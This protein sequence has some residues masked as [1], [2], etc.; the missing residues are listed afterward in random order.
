[1]CGI[2]GYF[3]SM[4]DQPVNP[5]WVW[6]MVGIQYHRGP[7][8]QDVYTAPGLALGHNR[9]SIIDL[10]PRSNQPM[11]DT[12]SG[13]IIVFNGEIYNY[14][15]LREELG[16]KGYE[17]HTES[18][19]EVLLKA[20]DEWGQDCVNHFNG[21]W[22][23]ALYDPQAK[24][25]FLSRDR[26]G[27][28]PLVYGFRENGDFVFASEAKAIYSTFPEFR[29]PN[30]PFIAS[31]I[32][33]GS[34]A[35]YQE[36]F[37]HGLY[38]LLP[39]NSLVL[40]ANFGIN[41]LGPEKNDV[42]QERYYR[43]WYPSDDF[44]Q[45]EKFTDKQIQEKFETLLQDA[46]RLRFRSDVP[47]GACLSGGLDS[48]TIVGLAKKMNL[49]QNA[50]ESS[51][52]TFSCVYP[53]SPSDDES[54]YIQKAV[55]AFGTKSY[56]TTPHYDH[57]LQAAYD[58]VWEQDGPTGG[59][60]VLSQ[61]SVMKEASGRVTVL[62]DGQ[63]ADE[64]LGG[65]H[66]LF[67]TAVN[68]LMRQYIRT[69]KPM[70]WFR[71]LWNTQQIEQRTG[72]KFEGARKLYKRVKK[73]PVKF[74]AYTASFSVLDY[75]SPIHNDDLNTLLLELTLMNLPSLL[76]YEDRNSMRFSLE[77]R[78]PFLDYRIV[79]FAFSLP[80]L[81]KIRGKITK[82]MVFNTAKKILP[83][84]ILNRKDK[85]GFNTPAYPWFWQNETIEKLENLLHSNKTTQ[86]QQVFHL[87]PEFYQNLLNSAFERLKTKDKSNPDDLVF[88]W[89]FMTSG[90][91]FEI[92]E[93]PVY[94]ENK[95]YAVPRP[96]KSSIS[97][98]VC[99]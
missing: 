77:S 11:V 96:T 79:E 28:K 67:P 17:F 55:D 58:S 95:L 42:K 31:F 73:T 32:Q 98:E 91:F 38:N 56:Q 70:Q 4:L 29:T 81:F 21:M 23:F 51:I 37:Y 59:P 99:R 76:H 88:L 25:L 36:T 84:E 44:S 74:N 52:S 80:S 10:D 89:R 61:R 3:S 19:T 82:W 27:V 92:L 35:G 64:V 41:T 14:L 18:D 7:D 62:L 22:S 63:G 94:A 20:Y 49:Y 71:Y 40:N 6:E 5:E 87:L 30:I 85:M 34:F 57:F 43:Y 78:L 90:L 68:T 1:M 72:K 65:Y 47:V 15:E 16:Y 93:N 53:D 83:P 12:D 45:T 46:I 86:I 24:H 50:K 97:Q 13:C 75:F 39:G 33:T 69:R 60:S 48:T 9:L 2:S 54:F 26:F 66:S 8:F